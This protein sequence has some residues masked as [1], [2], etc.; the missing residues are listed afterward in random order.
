MSPLL[1]LEISPHVVGLICKMTY[2]K[3]PQSNDNENNSG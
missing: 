1:K 3:N 2:Y